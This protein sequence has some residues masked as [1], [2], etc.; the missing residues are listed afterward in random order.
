VVIR[1]IIQR[2]CSQDG[3]AFRSIAYNYLLSLIKS[4]MIVRFK[5]GFIHDNK[6]Y[7]WKDKQLF[8]LPQQIGLR[9]YGLKEC[10]PWKDGF[11]L[12]SSRKSLSQLQSMTILIDK[13]IQVITDPDCPF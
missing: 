12:G 3:S 13:E 9:F 8:R 10:K 2:E 1:N 6:V 5:Y 7:G 11:V 4:V